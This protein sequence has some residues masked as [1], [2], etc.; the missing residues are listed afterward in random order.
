MNLRELTTAWMVQCLFALVLGGLLTTG[1][2][3]SARAFTAYVGA[4]M[5]GD[6][7][8]LLWPEVFWTFDQHVIRQFG[9]SALK[10]AIA[11]ELA[12]VIFDGFPTAQQAARRT[13]LA[14]LLLTLCGTLFLHVNTHTAEEDVLARAANGALWLFV[15]LGAVARWYVVPLQPLHKAILLGFG[16]FGMLSVLSLSFLHQ[17]DTL[18]SYLPGAYLLTLL[19]WAVVAWGQREPVPSFVLARA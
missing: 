11:G 6:L 7:S 9:Y 10:F 17:N 19:Y 4:V 18:R 14:I 8:A 16:T 3:K 13:V 2:W 5:I 12:F 1:L 15:G